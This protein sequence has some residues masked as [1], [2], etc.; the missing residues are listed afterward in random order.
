LVDMRIATFILVG[1]LTPLA[2]QEV[3]LPA[4][5]DKLAAKA[6]ESVDVTLDGSLLR[7]A[8]RF[9]SDRDNDQVKVKRLI[10]GLQGIYVRSFTFARDGEYNMADV[11]AL[12]AQ[13]QSPTW[14]RIVGVISKRNHEDVDVYFK[15]AGGDK[16]GGILVIAAEPRELTVVNIVG[17]ID[18]EQLS[19]LG[20]EFHIPKL[21]IKA[22][23]HRRREPR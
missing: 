6:E 2:A 14:S 23:Y 9:L 18:P 22:G 16:L 21:E 11:D 7:L 17:T 15:N 3:K 13:A 8:A 5:F 12:R 10:A 1:V 19:D 20:G 4:N